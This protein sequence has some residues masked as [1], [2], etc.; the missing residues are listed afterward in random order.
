MKVKHKNFEHMSSKDQPEGKSVPVHSV[1]PPEDEDEFMRGMQEVLS[2]PPPPDD[3][4]ILSDEV[5]QRELAKKKTLEKLVL[6]KQPVYKEVELAGARFKIKLLNVHES[7]NIS[8]RIQNMPDEDGS[9]AK[10]ALML[11]SAA[12]VSID[13]IP[14]ED[15]YS[16]PEEIEDPVMRRYHEMCSWPMTLINALTDAQQA[17]VQEVNSDLSTDFLEKSRKTQSTG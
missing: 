9:P 8:K 5:M 2:A 14:L 6:F 10:I 11:L 17:F 15:T 12:L 16:G 4:D 1:M 13:D 7:N 3:Q